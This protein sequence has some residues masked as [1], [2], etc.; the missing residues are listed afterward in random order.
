[1][2]GGDGTA[3]RRGGMRILL[4]GA[5]PGVLHALVMQLTG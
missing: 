5:E 3:G 1:M 2:A 4:G